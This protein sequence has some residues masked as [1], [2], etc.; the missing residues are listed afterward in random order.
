VVFVARE[1]S[2]A[3]QG[4]EHDQGEEIAGHRQRAYCGNKWTSSTELVTACCRKVMYQRTESAEGIMTAYAAGLSSLVQRRDGRLAGN[5]WGRDRLVFQHRHAFTDSRALKGHL[6]AQNIVHVQM[7]KPFPPE[8]SIN[9]GRSLGA[10]IFHQERAGIREFR[11][12]V[13]QK[14]G[15]PAPPC[16]R[17]SRSRA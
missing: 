17:W 12:I 9:R 1:S 13:P 8:I 5:D 11:P 2:G 4:E 15:C 14:L 6:V 16:P 7:S 3:Q 10:F